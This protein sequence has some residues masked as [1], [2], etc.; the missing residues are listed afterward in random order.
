MLNIG[1]EKLV[2][3]LFVA[4]IVLGPDKLST[5]V[6]SAGKTLAALRRMADG[7]HP[8]ALFE[9]LQPQS[10]HDPDISTTIAATSDGEV[11]DD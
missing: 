2:I 8:L 3:I 10:Q 9:D 5:S 7:I 4:L 6:R 11:P 1:P